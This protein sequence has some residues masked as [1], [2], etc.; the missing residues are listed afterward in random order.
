MAGLG[1]KD[2][3]VW[4]YL[5]GFDLVDLTETWVEEGP[6]NR[7]KGNLPAGLSWWCIPAVRENKKGRARGGVVVAAKKGLAV[8]EFKAWNERIAEARIRVGERDWRML[9]VYSQNIEETMKEIVEGIEEEEEEA[10]LIGG[11]FNAR[12]EEGGPFREIMLEGRRERKAKDKMINKEGSILLERV[13]ERGWLI[14]NGC[15]GREADWTY[16]AEKGSSIIDCAITNEKTFEEVIKVEEGERTESDHVPI[17]VEIEAP[18]TGKGGKGK[19]KDEWREVRRS[20][21]SAGGWRN[22]INA[23]RGGGQKERTRGLSGGR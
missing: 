21:W 15:Y 23:V 5:E 6:W 1:N 22:F 8:K 17:E 9:T 20:D 4:K 18:G 3:A 2:G 13:N 11:D 10:L 7:M 19:K 16:I 14:L 12:V